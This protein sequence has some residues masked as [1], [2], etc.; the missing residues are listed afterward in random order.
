[1]SPSRK[2]T[3]IELFHDQPT[4][5]HVNP[6]DLAPTATMPSKPR[7]VSSASQGHAGGV[8]M[9]YNGATTTTRP[10]PAYEDFHFEFPGTDLQAFSPLKAPSP[11]N[12]L[13]AFMPHVLPQTHCRRSRPMDASISPWPQSYHRKLSSTLHPRHMKEA[14]K[15]LRSPPLTRHPS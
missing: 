6:F 15:L 8:Y 4:H 12:S 10:Q 9:S 11:R 5:P 3:P 13:P 2:K 14:I 7:H 1:M